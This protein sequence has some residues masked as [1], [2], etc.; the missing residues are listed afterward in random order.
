[1]LAWRKTS[2]LFN[3]LLTLQTPI[4]FFIYK[5]PE[6]TQIVLAEIAR[7]KPK[8]L[9]VIAD[10]PKSN[11]EA[12][13][14]AA[15]RALIERVDWDCEVLTNFSEV[16]L[17]LRQRVASGISWVFEQCEE[18]I[19]LEDDCVPHPSF[20]RFCEELLE[21]YRDHDQVMM[22]AGTNPLGGKQGVSDSYYFSQYPITWGWATWR[23]A[24]R[25]YN[26]EIG[27]WPSLR[28]TKWLEKVFD[29]PVVARFYQERFD[30]V[31][32]GEV[33]TWDVQWD[34]TC[35]LNDGLSIMPSVNLITNIGVGSDS[36]HFME[37]IEGITHQPSNEIT[38]P[39]RH[40]TQIVKNMEADK[41]TFD[42][43]WLRPTRPPM[44]ITQSP[45]L[46]RRMLNAL[47]VS[48]DS[49]SRLNGY[50][51]WM[52]YNVDI[53]GWA[54]KQCTVEVFYRIGY[55]GAV[56]TLE[57]PDWAGIVTQKVD[58]HLDDRFEKTFTFGP[59]RYRL[60]VPFQKGRD[61]VKV[62][63]NS[64]HDFGL[65]GQQRRRSFRLSKIDYLRT[66]RGTGTGTVTRR[67]WSA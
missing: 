25:N 49:E 33:D 17:T 30:E 28:K 60:K 31:F 4:A 10:G 44:F 7:A 27:S 9:F 1:L 63:L 6:T 36:T 57:F 37:G 62:E 22:I 66:R 59:G 55:V 8:R 3:D 61:S 53:D 58:L 21:R 15:A 43:V 26:Q 34:Y 16:N 20:F 54:R 5:R 29:H 47:S 18:A 56:L 13:T 67:T 11:K 50:Y 41:L 32:A 51:Q 14:C 46:I 19:I 45:G 2:G 12:E 48:S 24:W 52:P 35:L 39:L 23:R 40:P 65:P 38:F 64:E 42:N